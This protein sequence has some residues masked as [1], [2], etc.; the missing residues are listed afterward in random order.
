LLAQAQ[1]AGARVEFNRPAA[2]TEVDIVAG[3]YRRP[4]VFAVGYRFATRAANGAWVCFDDRLTPG[5]YSYLELCDGRGTVAACAPTPQTGMKDN[6][7]QVVEGFRGRLGFEVDEPEYFAASI[8]YDL[9][10]TARRSGALYAGEA[11]GFQ[12]WLAGFGLR[13]AITT[14]HL[15]ARSL[16]EGRDYHRLWRARYS[17]ILEASAVNHQV[18][19]AA[20]QGGYAWLLRYLR[21]NARSGRAMLRRHYAPG[22][23]HSLV[24]PWARRL[25]EPARAAGNPSTA[26]HARRGEHPWPARG[27]S[28]KH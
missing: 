27:G 9:P 26:K 17:R 13:S 19:A 14:G 2:P 12:D 1:A 23:V 21:L 7:R 3:G 5:S 11:A 28:V 22:W 6:L 20:G 25:V 4:R 18:Q 10:P 15:S 8:G 16:L 24:W